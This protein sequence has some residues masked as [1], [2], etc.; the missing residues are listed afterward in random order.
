MPIAGVPDLKGMVPI[1]GVPDL[2]GMVPIVGVPDLKG[3]GA[4]CWG[5]RSE[6]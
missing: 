6:G 2:K 3:E 4:Y 5:A 1:V